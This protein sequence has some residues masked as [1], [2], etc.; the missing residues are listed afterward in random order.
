MGESRL[1]IR[2]LARKKTRCD[3]CQIPLVV[4]SELA[5]ISCAAPPAYP[6][7]DSSY[8]APPTRRAAWWC[9]TVVDLLWLW[10]GVPGGGAEVG[11]PEP[12]GDGV[13]GHAASR[14]WVAQ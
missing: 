9:S 12:C 6:A 1:A 8:I 13:H 7:L 10:G 4:I 14:Q 2:T 11:V 5:H 3:P